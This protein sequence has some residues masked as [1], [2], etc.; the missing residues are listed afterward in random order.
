MWCLTNVNTITV[1][2]FDHVHNSSGSF[3]LDLVFCL[4]KSVRDGANRLMGNLNV[5]ILETLL[6]NLWC[7]AAADH[8]TMLIGLIHLL[9]FQ[10]WS[11]HE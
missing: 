7:R 5:G 9:S 3:F 10:W 8:E 4:Y 2:I 1:F 11:L 6:E